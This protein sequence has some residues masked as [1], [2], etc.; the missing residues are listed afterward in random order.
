MSLPGYETMEDALDR[1]QAA[2]GAAEGHGVLCG[3]LSMNRALSEEGW[4]AEVL[5]ETDADETDET[6][7]ARCLLDALFSETTAQLSDVGLGFCMLL[8]EDAAPLDERVAALGRWCQGYLYGLGAAGASNEGIPEDSAEVIR[9]LSEIARVTLGGAADES[10]EESY[11][12]L[13]EFVRMGVLLI[14]EEL[15]PRRLH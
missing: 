6:G 15:R 2:L 11:G 10:G 8:P 12:E 13:V 14:R 7:E 1:A 9:D 3:M 5:P 4:I